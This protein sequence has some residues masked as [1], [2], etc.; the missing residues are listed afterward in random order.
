LAYYRLK[1][2]KDIPYDGLNEKQE[3]MSEWSAEINRSL[4]TLRNERDKT[5]RH[6]NHLLARVRFL[7]GSFQQSKLKEACRKTVSSLETELTRLTAEIQSKEELL[8]A[9][10]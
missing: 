6:I 2:T 10:V 7:E 1:P 9:L 5:G 4:E 3:M 8:T